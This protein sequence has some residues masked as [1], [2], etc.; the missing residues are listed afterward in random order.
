[1]TDLLNHVFRVHQNLEKRGDNTLNDANN[2]NNTS[3]V[4]KHVTQEDEMI[5][6]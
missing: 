5:K 4:N 6:Y 1:M 3:T 2:K